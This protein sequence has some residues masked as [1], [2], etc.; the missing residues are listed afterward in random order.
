MRDLIA[1]VVSRVLSAIRVGRACHTSSGPWAEYTH[2][3]AIARRRAIQSGPDT[4]RCAYTGAPAY[5]IGNYRPDGSLVYPG[6]PDSL[7]MDHLVAREYAC[8]HGGYAWDDAQIKK[9]VNDPDNLVPT[10][11]SANRWKS[12]HGPARYMPP[13]WTAGFARRFQM[14]TKRYGIAVPRADQR[15]IDAALAKE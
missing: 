8:Q 11:A 6:D 4:Y 2:G 5:R 15:A 7:Q 14:I 13:Q 12:D 9:F 1:A 3:E 10:T